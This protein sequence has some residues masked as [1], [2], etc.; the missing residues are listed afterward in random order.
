MKT[1]HDDARSHPRRGAAERPRGASQTA[2]QSS[3]LETPATSAHRKQ[4]E[5]LTAA[6][7]PFN[8][9]EPKRFELASPINDGTEYE[10]TE[11]TSEQFQ[12]AQRLRGQL[13]ARLADEGEDALADRLAKCGEPFALHCSN[14]ARIHAGEKKCNLKWCPVCARR[15]AAKL[16]M[17]YRRAAALM[18]WPMH[19]TLTISNTA[20]ISPAHLVRLKKA[21]KKLR[22]RDIF[23]NNV[24]GGISAIELTNTGRGWHLHL[25]L[26]L[27]C[28][29]LAI[30]TP[31]P[32][33]YHS[34]AHKK[35][36]FQR[37]SAELEREWSGLV[38]Q[39]LS[40]IAV[41]RCSGATAVQEVL[42]Y[43]VKAG[44]LIDSPDPIGDAIR[45]IDRARLVAPFGTLYKMRDELKE[46]ARPSFPCPACGE[47]KAWVP[48]ELV[49]RREA[50]R[51]KT[52]GELQ[53]AALGA[54]QRTSSAATARVRASLHDGKRQRAL[55]EIERLRQTKLRRAS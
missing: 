21:L 15:R 10:T 45:T 18:Q 34:R 3:C 8:H 7:D 55:A 1:L 5:T 36:L 33:K 25:H 40:S 11:E 48:D 4:R 30:E 9:P 20:T 52:R 43:A 14:C 51:T 31:R 38:D 6:I 32:K 24:A 23:A 53:R 22:R 49:K 50:P 37:A 17:K 28:E 12:Q 13:L 19:V 39:L 44:D 42:K 47:L 27:D 2:K 29:W 35:N 26:L 41:R 46:P 54:A 16:S